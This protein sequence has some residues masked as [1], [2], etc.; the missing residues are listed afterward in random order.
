MVNV[1]AV[2]VV[3]GVV[4]V[5]VVSIVGSSLCFLLMSPM[6]VALEKASMDCKKTQLFWASVS[7]SCWMSGRSWCWVG[8]CWW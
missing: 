3:A 2:W 8:Q 5:G 6:L 4:C 1:L 7:C